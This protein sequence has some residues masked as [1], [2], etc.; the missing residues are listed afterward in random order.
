MTP[1]PSYARVERLWPGSTVVC[2]GSGPSLTKADVESVRGRARVI[3]V[4]DTYRLAPW[5]DVLYACDSK[6]WRWHKGVPTFAGLRYS[7]DLRAQA[8]GVSVLRNSGMTGLEPDPSALKTGHNSGY[9]AINLAVHLGAERIV[10]LGYDMRGDHFFGSHPDQSRPPFALC[11][12][13]FQTLVE[14][15]AAAG[16]TVINASRKTALTVFPC[17]SLESVLEAAA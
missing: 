14:P 7:L 11:L 13:R 6:W 15:L 5:A 10:L 9:Q 8:F 12:K 16:V 4:N 2:L 3:A 17:A 1:K